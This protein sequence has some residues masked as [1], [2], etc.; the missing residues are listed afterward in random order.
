MDRVNK[1]SF[2]LR[3]TAILGFQII[4]G[5][6]LVVTLSGTVF[7]FSMDSLFYIS[8]A[9]HV[10]RFKGLVFSNFSVFPATAEVLPSVVLHPPGYP[11]LIALLKWMGMSAYTA[12]LVLPRIGFCLLPVLFFLV[13]R[14]LMPFVAALIAAFVCTFVFPVIKCS[15]MAWADVPYLCF[16]LISFLTAFWIMERKGKVSIILIVCAGALAGY[17]LLIKYIGMTLV[18]SILT[19][20][21]VWVGLRLVT[22]RVFV[23][24]VLF[25]LLGFLMVVGPMVIHNM[26][27]FRTALPYKMPPSYVPLPVNVHDYFR[28]MAQIIF[29][30]PLFEGVVIVMILGLG[31]L[32]MYCARVWSGRDPIS[33]VLGSILAAYFFF[34][35]IFLIAFKSVCYAPE[36]IDD[37]YLIQV[38][39]ILLGVCVW[40][41]HRI[42]MKIRSVWPFDMKM[43][44][45]LLLLAFVL[46]QVFPATDFFFFEE[47]LKSLAGKVES[48]A[49][50]LRALPQDV[51]IV[52]NVPDLTYYFVR[53]NVRMLA[54]YTPQALASVL[55]PAKDYVVFLLKEEEFLITRDYFRYWRRAPGYIK[56]YSDENVDL[57]MMRAS[58]GRKP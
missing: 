6:A 36:P 18:A 32:F 58:V 8:T 30:S 37:R 13:F 3:R 12:A 55:A 40:G 5:L 31:V 48:Y 56:I 39:W 41:L 21:V 57:L 26:I 38:A 25:Y 17:A 14:K 49:P 50:M 20:F 24:T 1:N 52:S 46:I 54:G 9:E 28:E 51:V 47:R 23:K 22:L 16:A 2:G 43:A 53:R 34:N 42:L 33:F 44:G 27:L 10:V 19:G 45:T 4:L 29:A 7:P 35:S 15:L 11:L